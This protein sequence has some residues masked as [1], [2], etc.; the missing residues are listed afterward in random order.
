MISSF[1]IG[2]FKAFSETQRIP[3]KPITL[4]Y[5]ANSSGK[6]SIIHALVLAQHAHNTGDLDVYNTSKGGDSIDF[7]GFR[8]Y[9]YHHD[10]GN[11][12]ELAFSFDAEVMHNNKK[13]KMD[14]ECSCSFGQPESIDGDVDPFFTPIIRRFEVYQGGDSLIKM[15]IRSDR[16]L[17]IDTINFE[18]SIFSN[19]KLMLT[20]AKVLG[21]SEKEDNRNLEKVFSSIALPIRG[22]LPDISSPIQKVFEGF[23]QHILRNQVM[24]PDNDKGKGNKEFKGQV[25]LQVSD[26]LIL[27]FASLITPIQ[28]AMNQL[29]SRLR[30]L[31]PLRT[32]PPR[33]IAGSKYN[34]PNWYAGGGFAWDIIRKDD[35]VRRKVN[36]WL[37]SKERL[38]TPYELVLRELIDIDQIYNT[39]AEGIEHLELDVEIEYDQEGPSGEHPIVRDSEFEVQRIID[40]LHSGNIERIPELVMIDKRSDTVVSHRDIG[41]GISQVL[42]VLA[43]SYANKEATIAIEQPEIHLHPALQADLSDVFIETALGPSKNRFLIETHSEH[44]LLRVMKRIRQTTHGDLPKGL[45]PLKPE[46][47]CV[48]F[49]QPDGS[50]SCVIEMPLDKNGDLIRSW[51][52]GFFE[53]G[54]EELF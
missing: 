34:D 27:S 38:Q 11:Q 32:Y 21:H 2:N 5:G 53:E 48:L 24:K 26:M 45:F 28:A 30:Y 54:L 46:D 17:H 22:I 40:S 12:V 51:P 13:Q 3:L 1:S 44:I 52:G 43:Y 25:E 49:V 41:V 14:F 18:S 15:S 9:V 37:S 16:K 47:V 33:H 4:I 36:M 20:A 50:S 42:P 35:D 31:G 10:L 6:S 7:G 39:L 23:N 19:I 29:C 8:Q